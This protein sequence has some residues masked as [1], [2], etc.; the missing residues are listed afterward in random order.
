MQCSVHFCRDKYDWTIDTANTGDNCHSGEQHLLMM[1]CININHTAGIISANNN[2][3]KIP[4]HHEDTMM[5]CDLEQFIALLFSRFLIDCFSWFLHWNTCLQWAMIDGRP[6]LNPTIGH[7]PEFD[8]LRRIK[9][10]LKRWMNQIELSPCYSL[11]GWKQS[12]E[13]K[14]FKSQLN[15]IKVSVTMMLQFVFAFHCL[16]KQSHY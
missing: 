1:A 11:A 15:Y 3:D 8:K 9:W 2:D 5:N 10:K 13:R 6:I 7:W 12:I 16:N 14:C 4:Q